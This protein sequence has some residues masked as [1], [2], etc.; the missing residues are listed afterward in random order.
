MRRSRS[1]CPSAEASKAISQQLVLL[2]KEEMGTIVGSM[3]ELEEE[4]GDSSV[5]SEEGGLEFASSQVSR[6]SFFPDDWMMIWFL[7]LTGS[8]SKE[9]FGN[10][11]QCELRGHRNG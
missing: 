6:V 7:S 5:S 4:E 3:K 8:R 1:I 2:Q 11:K 9:T 10:C